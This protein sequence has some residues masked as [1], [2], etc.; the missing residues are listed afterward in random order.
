MMQCQLVSTKEDLNLNLNMW[1]ISRELLQYDMY[2]LLR[3]LYFTK[4]IF[5]N[6]YMHICDSNPR[7]ITRGEKVYNLFIAKHVYLISPIS[8]LLYRA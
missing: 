7:S 1:L 8:A 6:F 4:Q 3:H 5:K 2:L